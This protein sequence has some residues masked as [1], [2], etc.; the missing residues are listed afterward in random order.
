MRNLLDQLLRQGT[1]NLD[2]KS[3]SLC[4][5]ASVL[6][7]LVTEAMYTFFY[8]NRATGSR[9]HRS[10]IFIGPSVTML[11]VC[12][13]LSLPL[14]LGLL[15]SL[16]IVRFRTPIREPEEIGFLMLL[17]AASIG[18]ATFNFVFVLMLYAATL[19]VLLV[20]NGGRV[21]LRLRPARG[22]VLLLNLDDDVYDQKGRD[23][24][25]KLKTHF[26]GL[27]LESVAS[28]EGT[29]NLQF[30]FTRMLGDSW[31]A[32]LA[33]LREQIP[34]KKANVFLNSPSDIT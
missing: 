17:I 26:R 10:F 29:T 3:F 1:L 16:S 20:R 19:A 21:L 4:L 34:Y 13:Q 30:V 6:I 32:F 24:A 2:A 14:S 31:S 22:G 15:G 12:V 25:A 33:S 28:T 23:L 9:I 27:R 7:A 5:A 11:F 8:E 18:I